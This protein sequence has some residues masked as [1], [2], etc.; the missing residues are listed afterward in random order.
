MFAVS[1]DSTK[2]L[3]GFA[4]RFQ[5]SYPLL[6]DEDS[7]V[8]RKFGILNTNIPEDHQWHG[9]PYPGTYMVDP[10]GRVFDKSFFAEHGIRESANNML[11]ESY[12]VADMQR[13]GAREFMT[14]DLTVRAYFASA[15][16]RPRQYS[17]LSVEIEP[18]AGLHITGPSAPDGYIPL[19]LEIN[20]SEAVAVESVAYPDEEI[21]YLEAL[22]RIH[23]R[24]PMDGVRTA[25]W[26]G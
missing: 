6:S 5:I 26:G 23:R 19:N 22:A 14:T 17:V 9:V 13:G 24:T 15:T 18:S 20:E 25:E 2:V 21:M 8:I 3:S 11:Q 7:R 16:I 4:E 1:Y 12:R 10:T